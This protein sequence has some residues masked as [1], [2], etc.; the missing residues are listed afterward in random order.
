MC[1]RFALTLPDDAMAR[2]FDARPANDLPLGPR[3]NICPT[4]SVSVVIS[5]AGQR[6]L[7]PMRWGF[8][9]SWYTHPGDGPLLFNARAETLAEK[10][11]FAQAARTRRCLIPA[12]AFYEWTKDAAGT[13]LPWAIAPRDGGL[14]AFAGV[15]QVWERDGARH[16]TCAIVTCAA[17]ATLHPLHERM[18]ILLAADK[19][20]L[21]LGERGHGAARLM[22]PAPEGLL[23]VWRVGPAV[24][25][26]KTDG[27]D[28]LVPAPSE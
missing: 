21:W 14:M 12:T 20:P 1:G 17:N 15:W 2:L 25:S 11:A 28:L 6:H 13:R 26:N 27:A 23:H 16:V 5:R 8:I 10:P 7:G 24:N 19:W 4:Q 18:P 22:E 3:Y 9:P